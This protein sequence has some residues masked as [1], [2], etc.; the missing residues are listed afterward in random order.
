MILLDNVVGI[1][2]EGGLSRRM[3]GREKSLMEINGETL[4]ESV[5][6]RL[7]SQVPRVVINANGDPNRFSR[8]AMPVQ[9]DTVP[10]FAGPLAGVLAGMRWTQENVP[11]ATHVITVAAD[12]PFFPDDYVV[13]MID[14]AAQTNS[15]IALA[16]SNG[17]HHPV[18]GLWRTSLADS[19]EEFLIAEAGRKVLLFVERFS[20]CLVEFP[21]PDESS[22][23][24]DPFFNVNTPDQLDQAKHYKSRMKQNG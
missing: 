17:R 5:A 21:S 15:D 8:L 10:G 19:L 9:A 7:A 24:P 11:D 1:V 12:T 22:G 2:L 6:Q 14:M 13:H 20:N 18:F 16:G 4:I 3:D 23:K